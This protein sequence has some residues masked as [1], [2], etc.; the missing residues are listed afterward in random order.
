[1]LT[2]DSREWLSETE[3]QKQLGTA[4]PGSRPSSL[5]DDFESRKIADRERAGKREGDRESQRKKEIHTE[6]ERERGGLRY[7]EDSVHQKLL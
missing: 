3:K 6:R 7:R 2:C 1:V 5:S 4:A